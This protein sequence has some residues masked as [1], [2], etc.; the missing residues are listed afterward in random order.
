MTTIVQT[1]NAQ[2]AGNGTLRLRATESQSQAAP[3][4]IDLD[5]HFGDW[6]DDL[7]RDGYVIIKGA[8]P[9][10]RA[11]DYRGD[12]FHWVEKWGMGFDKNDKTTWK[13]ENLPVVKKGG[14]F[15]H[16]VGHESFVWKVRQEPGIV[17]SFSKLWGTDELLVSFDGANL[18]LPGSMQNPDQP[19]WWHI[20][21]DPEKRGCI[22][23]QGLVNLN[24]NG[25]ND[26]GLRVLKNS[27][28]LNDEYFTKVWNGKDGVRLPPEVQTADFFGFTED[29]L[30]WFYQNGAEWVKP[31]M[32]TGDLV[33]WDARTAHYNIPPT[34]ERDRCAVY[35]C[36]APA[37]T[38]S[39]EQLAIKQHLFE[40][41]QMTTHW[42]CTHLS[43]KCM[44]ILRDGKPCP[45]THTK[46]F[47]E[48]ELTDRL[49]KLAGV[50]PY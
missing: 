1:Q 43:A 6:R 12:F 29:I 31:E 26:G 17:D 49:L 38:C 40:Q 19:A 33:L 44:P 27:H 7:A 24:E 36:F 11:S 30:E 22:C 20:D 3:I 9:Q 16:S 34:G 10:D 48:P 4:T 32:E 18:S 45:Y 13:P 8:I 2:L 28:K 41:R 25:A 5:K 15:H 42:P 50:K 47:D 35:T 23:V 46:P 39:P 14:M 21:Q 37:S